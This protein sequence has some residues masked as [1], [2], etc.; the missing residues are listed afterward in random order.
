MKF[1][2]MSME[3]W[4]DFGHNTRKKILRLSCEVTKKKEKIMH[5]VTETAIYQKYFC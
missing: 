4:V 3:V 2:L 1:Q 5:N